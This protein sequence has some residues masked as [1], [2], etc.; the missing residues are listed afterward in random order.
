MKDTMRSYQLLPKKND[1]SRENEIRVKAQTRPFVYAA[2]AGKLLFEK[3][4]A[5]VYMLATGSAT[6]K[7]IQSVEYVRRRLPDLQVCYEIESTEFLDEYE[8]LVEGLDRV[9]VRRLVPTLKAHLFLGQNAELQAK[10]GYM[11]ALP[12]S[13]VFDQDRF[14]ADVEEHFLKERTEP[15]NRGDRGGQRRGYNNRDRFDRPQSERGPYRGRGGQG[16]GQGRRDQEVRQDTQNGSRGDTQ[17]R[18]YRGDGQNRR[19][20]YEDRGDNNRGSGGY[21]GERRGRGGYD[22]ERR[23]RGQGGYEGERRGQGG[24]EGERRGQGG[25]EGERRGQGGYDG[26]RRDRDN[27][28]NNDRGERPYTGGQPRGDRGSRGGN[29]FRGQ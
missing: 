16:E 13:E 28:R 2:Y 4:H 10:P 15:H 8:P 3:K 23:G 25:Y 17:P 26:E 11:P 21:D 6:A 29:T 7:A 18:S 20:N 1:E 27:F 24:Y 12:E 5:S 14:R 19:R 9:Q 22:G